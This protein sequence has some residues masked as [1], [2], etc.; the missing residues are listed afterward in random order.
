LTERQEK[1]IFLPVLIVFNRE[2]RTRAP[3]RRPVKINRCIKRILGAGIAIFFIGSASIPSAFA[4]EVRIENETKVKINNGNNA[5]ASTIS[6]EPHY[7]AVIAACSHYKNPKFNIPKFPVPPFSNKKLLV[8]YETLLQSKNWDKSR[9]ILLLNDNATK[10]NITAALGRMAEIVGPDDFFL[11]SWSGHGTDVPDADGDE[12]ILDPGDTYDEAI[13]PY[14]IEKKN[15]ALFNMITDDELNLYFS[16]ITCRAMALIFDCCL[17]GGLAD[18]TKAKGSVQNQIE[19][20]AAFT[21]DFK[22]KLQKPRSSDVNGSNRV[23]LM[24]TQP[25]YVERG[26][27][28]TGFPLITGMAIA[29]SH[30]ELSDSNKDGFISAEEAFSIAQP[31]VSLQSSLLWLGLW[32]YSYAQYTRTME[33]GAFFY[34]LIDSC[35]EFFV[36]QLETKILTHH[37]MG[38]F[39]IIKDGYSGEFPLIQL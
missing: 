1:I 20:A 24:S 28:L 26:I 5:A 36:L 33:A 23:V 32:L 30:P 39:P 17:S 38:N 13:C 16:A 25:D 34:S 37:Y 15:G 21:G 3:D 29:C 35:L 2:F 8:F 14:D 31:L 11:F 27:F 22:K 19:A 18:R 7:Y 9:I 4:G 12:G 6:A 10:E